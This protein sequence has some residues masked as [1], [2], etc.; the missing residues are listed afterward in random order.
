MPT[1]YRDGGAWY[2]VVS[3]AGPDRVSG[4]R[5]GDGYAREYYRCIIDDGGMVWVYRDARADGWYL[6]GWWD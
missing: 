4:E 2:G 3:A 1:G 6:H 5:W